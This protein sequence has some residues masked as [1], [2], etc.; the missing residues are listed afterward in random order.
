MMVVR[1]LVSISRSDGFSAR[2]GQEIDVDD[3]VA[4]EL[5][6]N[7]QAEPVGAIKLP[8]VS[9]A[10]GGGSS[11]FGS[12]APKPKAQPVKTTHTKSWD[13]SEVTDGNG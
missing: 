2:I 3:G 13:K 4:Q 8:R 7:E 5:M 9:A 11:V 6:T 10:V 12:D 1:M